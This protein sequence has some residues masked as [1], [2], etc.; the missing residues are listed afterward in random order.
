MRRT[1]PQGEAK[2]DFTEGDLELR[3]VNTSKQAE[4]L[5]KKL[6]VTLNIIK[7][8][9][10]VRD[11]LQIAKVITFL[12]FFHIRFSSSNDC[13][14]SISTCGNRTSLGFINSAF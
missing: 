12:M 10:D 9:P 2:T 4:I 5:H 3:L 14:Y 13:L 7:L 8:I 6:S 1:V 11:L